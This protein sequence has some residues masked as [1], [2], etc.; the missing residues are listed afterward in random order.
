M[1]ETQTRSGV[2]QL[3]VF[4]LILV[5]TVSCVLVFG[6]GSMFGH[7]EINATSEPAATQL[8]RRMSELKIGPALTDEM[9][10]QIQEAIVKRAKEGDVQAA[11][12]VYEL[13]ARQRGNRKAESV[14]AAKK[15]GKALDAKAGAE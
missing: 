10:G 8:A 4:G 6:L 9:L 15:K 2:G 14:A 7:T 3:V 12:F 5:G 11:A 1:Y 13:A